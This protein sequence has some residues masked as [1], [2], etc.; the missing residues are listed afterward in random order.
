MAYQFSRKQWAFS[1]AYGQTII[2]ILTIINVFYPQYLNYTFIIFI[3]G[4][5]LFTVIT[6]KTQLKHITGK[7]AKEIKEGKRLFKSKPDEVKELQMKD[8]KLVQELKPMLKTTML[9]F[10][11]LIVLLVWYP[12]Y[13]GWARGFSAEPGVG[14]MTKV[15]VFLAGYEIPYAIMMAI[16][17]L[18]RRR[19]RETVQ[20]VMNYEVYDKG[21][22]GTGVVIKFPLDTNYV[23]RISPVRK[24]IEFVKTEKGVT[25]RYRLYTK[26]YE[27]LWGIIKKYGSPQKFEYERGRSVY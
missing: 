10:L 6:M 21:V 23:V 5:V 25:T 3:V 26:S 8:P 22:I 20:V 13:F 2:A 1:I 11:S 17:T 24:F 14:D 9:S 15:A 19:M 12:M 27:R 16:N 7:E 18:S 4:M